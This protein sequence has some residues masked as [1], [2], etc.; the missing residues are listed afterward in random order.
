MTT[1]T[2]L[3]QWLKDDSA[4]RCVLMEV[5]VNTGGVETTR[6]LSN[7]GYVTGPTD[8]PANTIYSPNISGGVQF[9]EGMTLDGS[10]SISYGDIEI[11]NPSGEKDSWLADIWSNRTVQVYIG[12]I[13]WTRSQFYKIFDGLVTSVSSRQRDKINLVLGDKLQRLNVP[14][15]ESILGGPT[16]NK[17]RLIP[18]LFG[19]CHNIEPLLTNPVIQEYQIHDGPIE[20][21]IEVRDNGVP[22]QFTPYLSTG[23]FRLVSQPVGTITVSAQG[24]KT[25][26]GYNRIVNGRF[27]TDLYNW[28]KPGA[29]GAMAWYFGG[30]LQ[31]RNNGSGTAYVVTPVAT[32][33]GKTYELRLDANSTALGSIYYGAGTTPTGYELVQHSTPQQ[34]TFGNTI[35]FVSDTMTFVATTTTMYI[36]AN[37][38]SSQVTGLG[39]IDN[40]VVR[41]VL[42]GTPAYINTIA[43]II[44]ALATTFGSKQLRLSDADIDAANFTAFDTANP[45]PVGYYLKDKANILDV[46]N[47]LASSIG[48]RVTMTK[49]GLVNLVKL[50]LPRTGTGTT[51]NPADMYEFSLAVSQVPAVTAGIRL[52]FCKNWTVQQSL[53]TGLPLDHINLYA[54]EWLTATQEDYAIAT[55]YNIFTV[56]D[57]TDTYLITE[58]DAKAEATRRLTMNKVQRYAFKYDAYPHLMLEKLGN[59]Q[60]LINARYGLTTGKTGQVISIMTD[61]L[62]PKITLEV[63][64]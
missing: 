9:T 42:S 10:T 61:W 17:D 21:I 5:G 48:G 19:E 25:Q 49:A 51:V 29:G 26:Y 30:Y 56:P 16:A 36:T 62:H 63:L 52:G 15:T 7:R 57:L 58:P 24:H 40:V 54:Q 3:I 23:K 59:T 43:P 37:I 8:S 11:Y 22:V 32:E 39:Y 45:Q 35:T 12:D 38:D 20:R 44:R 41:E 55:L 60:T 50:D 34:P 27:D 4:I 14:V 6:F 31:L 53:Q 13:S 47:Q 18:L 2:Q 33:I 46:C 28:T 64:V 1:D